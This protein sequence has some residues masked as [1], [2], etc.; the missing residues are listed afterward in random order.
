MES[1]I[2]PW[3]F[4]KK[5]RTL[6]VVSG[7][8][9]ILQHQNNLVWFYLPSIDRGEIVENFIFLCI[10]LGCVLFVCLFLKF[11]GFFFLTAVNEGSCVKNI[12]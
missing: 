5:G 1:I 10:C 9:K 7:K 12:L 2:W 4:V 8:H 11:Y 6:P 3:K